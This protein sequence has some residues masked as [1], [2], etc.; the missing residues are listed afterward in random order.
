MISPQRR[1]FSNRDDRGLLVRKTKR[2]ITSKKYLVELLGYEI[3]LHDRIRMCVKKRTELIV[4]KRWVVEW[5]LIFLGLGHQ[6]EANEIVSQSQENN[7]QIHVLHTTRGS[8]QSSAFFE[9]INL[10]SFRKHLKRIFISG[11]MSCKNE[12][13]ELELNQLKWIRDKI[14]EF[15]FSKC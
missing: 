6:R 12:K 15:T 1:K 4:V 8:C 9:N 2:K 7:L 5:G 10:R 11:K 3:T 14:R 13:K